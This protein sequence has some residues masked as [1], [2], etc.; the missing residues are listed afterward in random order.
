MSFNRVPPLLTPFDTKLNRLFLKKHTRGKTVKI[1]IT[2][3]AKLHLPV[4]VIR[5]MAVG[6][7]NRK[8]AS[9]L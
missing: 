8:R 9:A 2:G 6:L 7:G 5:E 3:E 1:E 4:I